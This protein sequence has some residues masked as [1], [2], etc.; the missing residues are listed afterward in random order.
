MVE[1]EVGYINEEKLWYGHPLLCPLPLVVMMMM[2]AATG[3]TL[4]EIQCAPVGTSFSTITL[5]SSFIFLSSSSP[6]CDT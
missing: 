3:C 4:G 1:R 5:P 6:T 2:I